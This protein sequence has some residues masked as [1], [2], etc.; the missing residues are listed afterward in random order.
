MT[1]VL[2]NEAKIQLNGVDYIVNITSDPSSFY[3]RSAADGTKISVPS[4]I[5]AQL[6]GAENGIIKLFGIYGT[7][8]TQ[9]TPIAQSAFDA[10][11]DEMITAGLHLVKKDSLATITNTAGLATGLPSLIVPGIGWA[12]AAL[13]VSQAFNS[14]VNI[15]N[16]DARA[17]IVLKYLLDVR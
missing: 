7:S 3:V 14:I 6:F 10:F 17:N 16:D 13:A 4:E 15:F 1:H 5:A 12:R 9:P 2:A 11:N 8:P